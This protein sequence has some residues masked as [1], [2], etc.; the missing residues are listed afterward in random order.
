MYLKKKFPLL[1]FL[2]IS[3]ILSVSCGSPSAKT[4]TAVWPPSLPTANEN[5]VA[6]LE[7]KDFLRV[8]KQVHSILDSTNAQL[9]VATKPP[10]VELVYHNELRN[11]LAD[12]SGALWSS[13]GEIYLASDGKVYSG[14]GNHWGMDNGETY[15]YCWDPEKKEL[16]K[17]A[18]INEILGAEAGDPRFSKVHAPI[19][20]GSDK[21]IYF[22]GTLDNGGLAG[23]SPNLD[24]WNSKIIGGKLFQYD[25]VSGETV[26]FADF[27]PATVTATTA[28]DPER[29]VFYCQLEGD[30]QG[31]SFAAFDMSAKKWIYQGE[32]GMVSHHRNMMMDK[33]GNVYFNGPRIT[34]SEAERRELGEKREKQEGISMLPLSEAHRAIPEAIT[35]LWKYDPESNSVSATNSSTFGGIRSSTR[36]SKSGFIFGTTMNDELFKYAPQRD[37]MTV[38]GSNFLVEGEYITVCVLS[39][40]EKYL[41]YLPGAHGS[42]GFSGTPV[43][44]Y[45]IERNE[46]KALVFLSETL[47]ERVGYAPGGTYGIQISDDGSVLYVGLNGSPADSTMVMPDGLRKEP[48]FGLTSF[49]SIY[50]PEEERSGE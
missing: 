41:Y 6:T 43:I 10:V 24:A 50:I 39:P 30:P 32:P 23:V 16:K 33:D 45:N 12:S 20:E 31:V 3:L 26:V 7:S 13:W 17:V 2:I 37:E 18:D 22:T 46:Q 48:G 14:T 29:N 27:P 19:F 35:P 42:A 4:E 36:E 38:L 34:L 8:P 40:D 49:A 25:P 11:I 1:S 28:Y 21:K 15:I 5:G 9:S 47:A 44:Q